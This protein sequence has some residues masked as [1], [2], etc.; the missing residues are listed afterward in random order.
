MAGTPDHRPESPYHGKTVWS[1]ELQEAP[2]VGS[3]RDGITQQQSLDDE[4]DAAG[5]KTKRRAYQ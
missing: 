4:L 5:G 2:A 1:C 3:G